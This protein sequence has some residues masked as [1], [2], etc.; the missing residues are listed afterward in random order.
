MDLA[1]RRDLFERWITDTIGPNEY[2][3]VYRSY[4]DSLGPEEVMGQLEKKSTDNGGSPW[5]SCVGALPASS[6]IAGYGPIGPSRRPVKRSRSWRRGGVTGSGSYGASV[7]F[8][9]YHVCSGPRS[10]P[11]AAPVH[12][13]RGIRSL[14]TSRCSGSISSECSSSAESRASAR[15]S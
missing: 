11:P 13:R 9:G 1:P 14:R 15:S 3:R 7:F 4:L 6:A 8:V 2:T 12:Q 10:P 5:R